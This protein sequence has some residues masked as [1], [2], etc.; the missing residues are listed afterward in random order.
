[1]KS[2]SN[3]TGEDTFILV[4]RVIGAH[5]IRG[6]L[7]IHSY[8]ESMDLYRIG[9]AIRVSRPDGS[10]ERMVVEWVHP[11]G[12]GLRMGLESVNDR[13]RAEDLVGS[14]LFI[15]KSRL[16]SLD[17]DTYYWSELMGLRVYDT[18]G[19]LLGRLEEV[20]PTGANDVYV[21]R[22][23]LDGES[24]ELLLPAI[25]QVVRDI[26]LVKGKMIVDPPEG[27]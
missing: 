20:I 4:G 15:D 9:E 13:T 24:R 26:D 25:G 27:L 1:L 3:P 23:D 22:G 19:K 18:G 7:K 2:S 10:V 21:I 6:G 8:A 14:S 16:P 17:E 11:H 5:G 12:R